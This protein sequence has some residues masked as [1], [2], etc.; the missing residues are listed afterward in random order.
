MFIHKIICQGRNVFLSFP[1]WRKA[2][3][4]AVET[5]IEFP[6]EAPRFDF[7]LQVSGA[8]GNETYGGLLAGLKTLAVGQMREQFALAGRIEFLDIIQ[9]ESAERISKGKGLFGRA[10]LTKKLGRFEGGAID[11]FEARVGLEG[12]SVN[13]FGIGIFPGTAF[14]NNQDR[15]IC[16]S[17]FARHIIQGL[18]DRTKAIDETRQSGLRENGCVV[19]AHGDNQCRRKPDGQVPTLVLGATMGDCN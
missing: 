18:H 3:T 9:I 10:E 15:D 8:R 14:A 6:A 11:L 13:Q 1:E 4:D 7:R 12:K 16:T 5:E 2:Q 19:L 17:N